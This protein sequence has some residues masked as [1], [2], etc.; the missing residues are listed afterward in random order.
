MGIEIVVLEIQRSEIPRTNKLDG[1]SQKQEAL[2]RNK[3]NLIECIIKMVIKGQVREVRHSFNLADA[4]L[5]KG[6]N[7]IKKAIE[8]V[9]I[10]SME[11][12]FTLSS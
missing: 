11:I 8:K 12:G 1:I 5:H 3:C 9:C 10:H 7:S 6:K 2:L 4:M